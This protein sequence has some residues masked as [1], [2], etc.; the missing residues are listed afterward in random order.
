MLRHGLSAA[1]VEAL[2]KRD[3]LPAAAVEAL[4]NRDNLP[5]AAA[6]AS[7][8]HD[9]PSAAAPDAL[10]AGGYPFTLPA[11]SPPTRFFWSAKKSAMTG[12][13]TSTD[14]AANLPH[15]MAFSP[16]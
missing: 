1:A 8:K 3:D 6:D 7:G 12:I 16:T 5:A 11:V 13:E 10:G 4:G 15:S 14:E 9:I 2:G